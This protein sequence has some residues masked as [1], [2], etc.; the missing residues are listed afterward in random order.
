MLYM[1]R[2]ITRERSKVCWDNFLEECQQKSN[3]CTDLRETLCYLL[4]EN[5]I[6]HVI[7]NSE[8][9]FVHN[10]KYFIEGILEGRRKDLPE[11]LTGGLISTPPPLICCVAN[12][13]VSAQRGVQVLSVVWWC[14]GVVAWLGCEQHLF[15]FFLWIALNI[16]WGVYEFR[17]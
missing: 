16:A 12:K 1:W 2:K 9:N 7:P 15:F 8:T 10:I 5:N 3:C 6:Y 13:D 4:S 17:V 11:T 14:D